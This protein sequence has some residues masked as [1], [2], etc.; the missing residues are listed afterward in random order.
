MKLSI[1][2]YF[3]YLLFKNK[4]IFEFYIEPCFCKVYIN[5]F[6]TINFIIF[7]TDRF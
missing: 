5:Y 7:I 2:K 6:I 1:T 4:T 3:I